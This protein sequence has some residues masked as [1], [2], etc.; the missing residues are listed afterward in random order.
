MAP[1]FAA[2]PLLCPP[3]GLSRLGA[4]RR[5]R[6]APTFAAALLLCP[7]EGSSPA[8]NGPALG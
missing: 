7:L 8:W 4:A 3:K 5:R 6:M 2:A 1:T